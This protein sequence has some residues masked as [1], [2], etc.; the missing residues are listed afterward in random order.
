MYIDDEEI[1]LTDRIAGIRTY[2]Q[3]NGLETD[4]CTFCMK[5]NIYKTHILYKW[6]DSIFI[7]VCFWL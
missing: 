7:A 3:G 2:V 4:V 1:K 5:W 6:Y